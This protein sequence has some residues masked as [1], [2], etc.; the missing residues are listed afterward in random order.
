M[1]D[2]GELRARARAGEPRAL[3]ELGRR[4][5]TGHGVAPSPR[6]A[7]AALQRAA[8]GKDAE[9]IALLA[10]MAAWGALEP[11]NID[12]ALDLL[13]EAAALGWAPARQELQFIA[14]RK[15][16]D[17]SALRAAIDVSSWTAAPQPTALCASPRVR[18]LEGFAT[19]A[20][21][22][23]MIEQRRQGMARAQ[24]YSGSAALKTDESRTNSE[25]GYMIDTADIVLA[26]MRSRISNAIDAPGVFFE[27]AKLLHYE[28]HQEFKLHSDFLEPASPDLHQALQI[29]GQRVATF[30]IY[31]N[32]DYEGGA[33][34]FPKVNLRFKGRKGDALFFLN[35]NDNGAPDYNSIH[36][37]LPP[38]RGEK[39]LFSQWIRAKPI[40][41][42]QTPGPMPAPLGP[43][44][45]RAR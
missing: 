6:D 23:W 40:N 29:L 45:L 43:D 7:V 32:D 33:T 38:T 22:D 35:V 4:L 3:G 31:L 30:L 27:V 16:D 41:A 44:W 42:M 17:W 5:L 20:E 8:H 26:L 2:L 37:G 19:A 14:R 15:S 25:A 21:C 18:V 9:A 24:V 36:A 28:P 11:Q 13:A 1:T 12:R 34:E 39:W 10:R